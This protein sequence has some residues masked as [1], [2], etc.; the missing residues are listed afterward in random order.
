MLAESEKCFENAW[1]MNRSNLRNLD[2][3]FEKNKWIGINY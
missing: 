2:G 3:K 1:S